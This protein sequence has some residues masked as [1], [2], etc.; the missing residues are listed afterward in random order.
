[1]TNDD[2]DCNFIQPTILTSTEDWIETTMYE[3]IKTTIFTR[4]TDITDG[5][6]KSTITTVPTIESS[7][8][9]IP[10]S[11]LSNNLSTNT[12]RISYTETDY[13]IQLS[14]TN[15]ITT[16]INNII[17]STEEIEVISKVSLEIDNTTI[18]Y[19]KLTDSYDIT[20]TPIS[21][22]E[23]TI[24]EYSTLSPFFTNHPTESI[25]TIDD[26]S[27]TSIFDETTSEE[28]TSST[29]WD[30]ETTVSTDNITK[31]INCKQTPCF[32]GGTCVNT[33]SEG[34]HVSFIL[35]QNY[36]IKKKY[37]IILF[38]INSVYVV[39]IDKDIYVSRL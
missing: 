36:I 35:I 30:T 6:I 22:T 34:S 20:E 38:N 23:P 9:I 26:F 16:E 3:E 21:R 24:N 5:L 29:Y 4:K 12:D 8:I 39:L 19:N 31:S 18:V 25:Y 2:F 1:M 37:L 33:T 17:T 14:S 13:S 27:T 11:T 10:S 28:S 7:S 32:N 15:F